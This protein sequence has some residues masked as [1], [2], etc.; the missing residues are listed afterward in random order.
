MYY[1]SEEHL[2]CFMK[3]YQKYKRFDNDSEMAALLYSISSAY[4]LRR[5]IDDFID[6]TRE[7]GTILNPDAFTY[8][9]DYSSSGSAKLL[10]LG[11][12]LYT[13]S[14]I[15]SDDD[16]LKEY[17]PVNIFSGLDPQR[18]NVSLQALRIRFERFRDDMIL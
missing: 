4:D 1:E 11:Y 12:N 16:C 3:A 15:P 18:F 17:S 7:C 10:R 2:Y 13:W 9:L 6:T 14:T 8:W 5:V